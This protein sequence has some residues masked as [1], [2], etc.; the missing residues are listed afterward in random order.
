METMGAKLQLQEALE[1]QSAWV[2]ATPAMPITPEKSPTTGPRDLNFSETAT[3]SPPNEVQNH[4]VGSH[5]TILLNPTPGFS[6]IHFEN[7]LVL[8]N[9]TGMQNIASFAWNDQPLALSNGKLLLSGSICH[10]DSHLLGK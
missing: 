9:P 3:S 10:G 1:K 5:Q 8:T 7:V 6:P 4:N 2:L